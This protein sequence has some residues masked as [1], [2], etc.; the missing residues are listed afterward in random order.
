MIGTEVANSFHESGAS[1]RFSNIKSLLLDAGYE[2]TV[3]TPRTSGELLNRSWDLIAV[4]SFSVAR[5][6]QAAREKTEFLWFDPTDSWKLTRYS[7]LKSGDL[8]Q[9]FALVRDLFW[10]LKAPK[11]DLLTFI[12]RRDSIVEKNWWKKRIT[13]L[14]LP[15]FNLERT[16]KD[17][18]DV[19][20]VFVGDGRYVPNKKSLR[21][22]K[23]LV[24]ELPTNQ[25][26]HLYGKGLMVSN[27]RFISH[28][29]VN[30][31]EI[32]YKNDI[33]LAPVQH[34]A[35]MKLKVVM[36]LS[37]GIRVIS[38]L[39]GSAGLQPNPLLKVA[40]SFPDFVSEV[41]NGLL[42][43]TWSHFPLIQ[44]LYLDDETMKISTILSAEKEN[45]DLTQK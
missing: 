17:S 33:H 41:K 10:L 16:L 36:P 27:S 32:Y 25:K 23:K 39:E 19:R 34:G 29:Y 44:N 45:R 2:V 21:Y 26:V 28:G 14:V 31:E 20:L 24:K 30:N 6:L 40:S 1:I 4:V 12:T 42:L 11:I 22:L 8:K 7:L 15:V 9:I 18:N 5:T 38:T 37:N 35:G 3:C 43:E 13:P